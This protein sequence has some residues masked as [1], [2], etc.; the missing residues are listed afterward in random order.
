MAMCNLNIMLCLLII[1]VVYMLYNNNFAVVIVLMAICSCLGFAGNFHNQKTVRH[2]LKKIKYV[3]LCTMIYM[4]TR[5]QSHGQL[6]HN[7][8]NSVVNAPFLDLA[9]LQQFAVIRGAMAIRSIY[10]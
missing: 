1:Q 9:L 6:H 7:S 10:Q 8:T 3:G 4:L 2:F 5:I